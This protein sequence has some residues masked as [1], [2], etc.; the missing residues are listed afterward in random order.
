MREAAT[1]QIGE[2]Q[3]RVT[4]LGAK[5]GMRVLSRITSILGDTVKAGAKTEAEAKAAFVS[6]LMSEDDLSFFCDQFAPNTAVSVDGGKKWP[7]LSDVFDAHFMAN[8]REMI[9][10]VSFA[11]E[12]N[13]GSFFGGA[14]SES[15]ASK[16][17]G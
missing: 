13:F 3:Y 8:Y 4:P 14:A 7:T 11:I 9:E 1:K 10:W 2:S 5:K 6:K 12:V 17:E 15:A 16:P